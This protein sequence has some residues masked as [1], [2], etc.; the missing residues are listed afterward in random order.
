MPEI[1]TYLLLLSTGLLAGIAN[2]IAGGG[3]FFIFPVFLAIGLPPVMANASNAISVWPGH[4]IAVYSYRKELKQ[5][6]KGICWSIFLCLSGGAIGA[7]LLMVTDNSSFLMLVPV[8]VGF[9]TALFAFSHNIKQYF[10]HKINSDDK[11]SKTYRFCEVL[12]SIYGGFFG[13]GLGIMLMASLSSLG[14][15]DIHIN[16]ALKNLLAAIVTSV[17]VVIFALSGA[18]NWEY[19]AVGFTGA[20]VGGVLGS[21]LARWLPASWLKKV[22][23]S[24]GSF[25]TVF[26]AI[27][28][29]G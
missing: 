21:K 27:K 12:V 1:Y 11:H 22:V 10:G 19:A 9:A 15:D 25:L 3:T 2:A 4:A 8:L 29:Y 17:A 14:I 6:S 20:V 24:F 18:V 28:F 5:Y 13:A 23:I 26:Y 16:N 7:L